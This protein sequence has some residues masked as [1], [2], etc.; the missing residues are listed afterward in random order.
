MTMIDV[1][2]RARLLADSG[3]AAIVGE[4]V[5]YD[6][7]PIDPTLP[8]IRVSPVSDNPDPEVPG[9]NF[10]RVQ[11]SCYSDPPRAN[12]VRSPAELNGLV[13]AVVSAVHAP[14]LTS[15]PTSWSTPNGTS[16]SIVRRRAQVG[17]RVPEPVSGYLHVPVDVLID[18][19]TD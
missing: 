13:A 5:H 12:G 1:A 3:V 2:V 8:A 17:P 19:N 10:A 9:A 18:F 7:L 11:V 14:R 4:R 15:S 6:D 16:Y